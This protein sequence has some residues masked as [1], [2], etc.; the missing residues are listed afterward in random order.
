VNEGQ[1]IRLALDQNFPTP[2]I[3]AVAAYLPDDVEVRSLHQID[4]RLSDLEDRSLLIALRQLGWNGL[5]TNNYRMLAV[6]HE[7]AAII[8]TR[9]TGRRRRR[10]WP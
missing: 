9:T 4:R 6:P 5:I 8:K 2:L 1:P 10:S 7:I 3:R